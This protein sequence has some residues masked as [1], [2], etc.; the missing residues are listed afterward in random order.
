[1]TREEF[2]AKWEPLL[3]GMVLDGHI[4]QGGNGAERWIKLKTA[5]RR[6][7]ENLDIIF[8]DLTPKGQK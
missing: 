3:M 6:L 1:M 7:W 8:D 4:D 5:R 2:K